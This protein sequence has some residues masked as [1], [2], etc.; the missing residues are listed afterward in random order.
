MNL[1]MP[2]NRVKLHLTR[3]YKVKIVVHNDED[4]NQLY[5]YFYPKKN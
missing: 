4:F 2:L 5:D 3:D 1:N